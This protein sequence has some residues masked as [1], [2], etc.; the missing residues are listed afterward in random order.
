MRNLMIYLIKFH[1]L[2][3]ESFKPSIAQSTQASSIV[4]DVCQPLLSADDTIIV[5]SHGCHKLD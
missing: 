4:R 1:N 2:Q 5:L 3:A